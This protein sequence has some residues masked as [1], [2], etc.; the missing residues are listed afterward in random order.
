VVIADQAGVVQAGVVL[1]AV[2]LEGQEEVILEVRDQEEEIVV[3]AVRT[4]VQEI[5]RVGQEEDQV[6]INQDIEDVNTIL[7]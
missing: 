3:V 5:E 2:A 6:L 1:V 4:V 7:F